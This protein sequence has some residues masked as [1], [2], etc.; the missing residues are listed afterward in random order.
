MKS[1]EIWCFLR[2][3]STLAVAPFIAATFVSAFPAN[4]LELGTQ[5]TIPLDFS[6]VGTGK[7]NLVPPLTFATFKPSDIPPNH[8]DPTLIGYRFYFKSFEMN[9][10]VR[11]RNDG[12]VDNISGPFQTQVTIGFQ[13]IDNQTT[14]PRFP[15]V[16]FSPLVSNDINA[17]LPPQTS[18]TFDITGTFS[19]VFTSTVALTPPIGTFTNPPTPTPVSTSYFTTSWALLGPADSNLLTNFTLAGVRG[20]VGVQYVYQ[21]VPGPLPILGSAAAFGWSRRLRRRITQTL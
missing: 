10:K 3:S 8:K 16:T 6:G 13:N 18:Q 14:P 19:D 4:A 7:R 20:K 9:G 12:D 17:T 5:D 15:D 1:K 2:T 21:Y 11:L